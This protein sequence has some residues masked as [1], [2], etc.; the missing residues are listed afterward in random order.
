M[1]EPLALLNLLTTWLLHSTVLLGAAI[2]APGWAMKLLLIML[3]LMFTNPL[4]SQ[5][6]ARNAHRAGV[7]TGAAT[8][9]D[10]LVED[11]RDAQGLGDGLTLADASVH[12]LDGSLDDVVGN[13]VLDDL[14]G[15]EELL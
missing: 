7:P 6:L 14:E 13:G 11:A 10:Q 4:S 5:V 15:L 2:I 1:P 9:H 8:R 3:F 12:F